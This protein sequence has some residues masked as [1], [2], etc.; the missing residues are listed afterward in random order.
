MGKAFE[1]RTGAAVRFS[2]AG[3]AALARQIDA[4]GPADVFISADEAWMDFVQSRELIRPQSR[5]NLA[6][7]SLVLIAPARSRTA[8]KIGPRFRLRAA[9]AGGRLAIGDPE[10]VPAGRYAKT[11]LS[12]LG[13]WGD[14][15]DRLARAENVRSAMVFVAR[16][17][18]PLGIVYRTD[19]LAEPRVRI[20]DAF[21]RNSHPPIVYPAALTRRAGPRAA[22]FMG[23]CKGAAGREVLHRFG[24]A[25]P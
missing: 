7:N 12:S 11:A 6:G 13:V 16:G 18:A 14:V 4:G 17:E 19:A 21:P 24:F 25:V 3:S 9:L 5:I 15:D 10:V 23:F 20:V 8:L 22:E 1:T 2:F